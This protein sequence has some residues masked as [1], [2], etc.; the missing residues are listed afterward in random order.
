ME[1]YYDIAFHILNDRVLVKKQVFSDKEPF[2]AWQDA[3]VS[4][5]DKH[6]HLFVDDQYITLNRT[7]IVRIDVRNVQDPLDKS[8][9]RNET[10]NEIKKKVTDW[11]L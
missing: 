9:K 2:D 3:C 11:G 7:Y 1:K 8:M 4:I 10:V 5:D 6:L